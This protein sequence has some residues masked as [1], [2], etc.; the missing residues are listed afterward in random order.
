[1]W[2]V[3]EQRLQRTV[4]LRVRTENLRYPVSV[5]NLA[6]TVAGTGE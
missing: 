1:M 5:N 3:G 4:K 6:G 2:K